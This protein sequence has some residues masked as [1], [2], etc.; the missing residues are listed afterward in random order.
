MIRRP[1]R[2]TLFPYTTLFRSVILRGRPAGQEIADQRPSRRGAG[3]H[4]RRVAIV[5]Q[6][7]EAPV[8]SDAEPGAAGFEI[9]SGE[10]VRMVVPEGGRRS[11]AS[12]ILV[13][14]GRDDQTAAG[15]RAPGKRDEAHGL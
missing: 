15:M 8:Q 2:S 3:F 13:A 5:G 11:G 10:D 14:V 6:R 4:V 9:A 7:R 1:P 12:E